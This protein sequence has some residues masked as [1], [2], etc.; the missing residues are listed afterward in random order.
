[1]AKRK[2]AGNKVR[3]TI[4]RKAARKTDVRKPAPPREQQPP[5]APPLHDQS[6]GAEGRF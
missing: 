1:M 3:K 4:Q 2:G 5:A 6:V